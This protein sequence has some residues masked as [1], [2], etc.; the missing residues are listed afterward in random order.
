MS[1]EP[2]MITVRK[3][4]RPFPSATL[5]VLAKHPFVAIDLETTGPSS[6]AHRI[7]EVGA[8]KMR[9]DGTVIDT[10]GTVT[11]PGDDVPLTA[12]AQR[13]HH[14]TPHEI[15][16]APPLP[17]VLNELADFIGPNGVVAHNIPFESRFLSAAFERLDRP[18]P[19]WQGLCTLA[20]ARRFIDA[21]SHK[22]S[23]L[24]E[25]LELDARNTH[26]AVDDA[27]ACGL[28]A[29]YLIDTLGVSDLEPLTGTSTHSGGGR[30]DHEQAVGAL[31]TSLGATV[32][33]THQRATPASRPTRATPV[34]DIPDLPTA[35]ERAPDTQP[36]PAAGTRPAAAPP[37]QMTAAL[38][39]S[40]FGGHSPTDEQMA[41]VEAFQQSSCLRLPA[42]AGTG[43]TSTLLA[44][45]RIEQHTHA[46]RRGTYVAFN[47]SVAKEAAHKFPS[48]V[49][50]MT[51]HSLAYK[52]IKSTPY[53]A[54]IGKL[55]QEVPKW[56]TT[57]EAIHPRRTVVQMRD[58]ERLFNEYVV[59]RYALRAVEEFCKTLDPDITDAHM[60]PIVGIERGSQ[61]EQQ[62]AAAVIP[63]ARRAWKNLLD[64]HS[65]AVRFSHSVYLKLY[66]DS[67]PRIGR[68]GD[69]IFLDEAQDSNALVRHII[70]RQKHLQIVLVGDENQSIYRFTGAVN[71]MR[72][73]DCDQTV[74]LTQS[75]RFGDAVAETANCYLA[76]LH[77]PVRVRGNPLIDDYVTFTDTDATAILARTNGG[78]VAEVIDA[79]RAGHKVAM[80]GK[81]DEAVKFC[82]TAR[83]LLAGQSPQDPTYAAFS[84]WTDLTEWLEN[85]PGVSDVA[86]LAKLIT[87]NGVDVIESALNNLVDPR[88]A[89]VTV[90]TC[91]RA[92]GLEFPGVRIADD[93]D[94]PDEAPREGPFAL[95]DD[96]I[97]DEQRLA[98]VALTRAQKTLNP[99]RLLKPRDLSFVRE[100]PAGMLL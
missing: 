58:G 83:S 61:Q 38:V 99:G 11:N 21:P 74:H 48:T 94:D 55:N 93:F 81:N 1:D 96:D 54:L 15:R 86:V 6:H 29:A 4:R 12:S 84:T 50:A 43:K 22:L 14:I 76:R 31:T 45:A 2:Q 60:P 9:A 88:R 32:I 24:I 71:A 44:L 17:V 10:F 78:A 63:C 85:Q 28:L 90:A 69:F 7:V 36:A 87:D 25:L 30:V 35:P 66:A 13:I 27:H 95:S 64:P 34:A 8:V 51:A 40:A 56:R 89:D 41:A 47:K 18:T 98:Y 16:C 19:T 92:K 68:D 26:R 59:G 77:A 5:G 23:S 37:A 73:F 100:A 62:L 20:T 39:K 75:F 46:D 67:D 97:V 53:G 49:Q 33:A 82:T 52:N 3:A 80:I 57:A 72:L 42:L 70:S 65:M 91:H 79:Q